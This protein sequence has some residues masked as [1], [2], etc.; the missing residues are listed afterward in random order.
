MTAFSLPER[1]GRFD[2]TLMMSVSGVR[3]IIGQTMT[4]ML[5]AELGLAFGSH[6][7]GGPVVIGRD[8]RPSGPMLHSAVIAGLLAAGCEVVDVGLVSTPGAA[9]MTARHAAS[10][11][12]M[13]TASH[14]PIDW[15]GIK[16]FTPDGCA[17]PADLAER[18]FQRYRNKAF[19]LADVHHLGRSTEDRSADECHVKAVLDVLDVEAIRR[20][21]FKVV[22][23]S[24]NGAGCAS[25]RMLLERLGCD[26]IHLNG[27]P[28]G[29]FAHPPEPLAENLTG[30]CEAVR[31]HGAAIGFAQDP[32]ADRLALVDDAGRYIGEEYTL[33]LAAE[34]VFARRSGPAAT[35]LST[36]RMIDDL[37]ARA[38]RGIVVHRSPV[39]EANVVAAMR[40]HDCVIGG[41]GNGG[42]IDPR[43][44]LVRDSLVAMGFVLN[45]IADQGRP[46]TSIVEQMPHYVMIKRKLPMPH[47][48][49]IAWLDKL[50]RTAGDAKVNDADGIRLDW[51]AGWVH[52][53]LSNTEPIARII[54]EAADIHT[55][56]ALVNRALDCQ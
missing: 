3:G 25:G 35:N 4:P 54:A 39:G 15:N 36:S 43:I 9:L 32:D 20:A 22:L 48:R 30:L 11:G 21:Q 49:T 47:D 27:Q 42:V 2:M 50:R 31:G 29:L 33:A 24:V 17:L 44:V 1:N 41:E 6:V 46:L 40:Q 13:I 14:N 52:V 16:F 5:A 37:A 7:G 26:V 38:G 55:T 56:E 12:I 53:R 18:V 28:T 51:P 23:D 45:L 10:G 19:S 8:P 34:F